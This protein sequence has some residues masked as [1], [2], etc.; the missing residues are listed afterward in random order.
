M[1]S[2]FSLNLK[3]ISLRSPITKG[4]QRK[5]LFYKKISS[6]VQSWHVAD[7]RPTIYKTENE[8]SMEKSR[9]GGGVC[10]KLHLPNCSQAVMHFVFFKAYCLMAFYY[11]Q[12]KR[13]SQLEWG[14]SNNIDDSL[15]VRYLG[16]SMVPRQCWI[17]VP[18]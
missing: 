1:F 4:L 5:P 12:G 6:I 11:F 13:L 15:R 16:G 18:A 8:E 9:E 7:A 2:L 3:H 14:A 10:S 17:G